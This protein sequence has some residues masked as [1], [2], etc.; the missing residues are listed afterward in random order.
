M[1]FK[2]MVSV[3]LSTNVHNLSKNV[4]NT[5]KFHIIVLAELVLCEH[6]PGEGAKR[7]RRLP[8]NETKL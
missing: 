1:T 7:V 6:M 5:L 4:I 8:L 2:S 3:P